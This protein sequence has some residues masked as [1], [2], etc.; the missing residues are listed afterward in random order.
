MF[1]VILVKKPNEVKKGHNFLELATHGDGMD[2]AR[3]VEITSR[4]LESVDCYNSLDMTRNY[5]IKTTQED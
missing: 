2:V 5:R 1:L 3:L 4:E